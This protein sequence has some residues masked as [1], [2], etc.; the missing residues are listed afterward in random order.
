MLHTNITVNEKGHLTFAGMDTVA[1]AE[2]YGT[3]LMLIDENRIRERA[4][5]YIGA[6]ERYFGGESK[7]LY[8]SKALSFT[9]IYKIIADAGMSIDIVSSGELY[10]AKNAGFPLENAYFHGNN[11]TDFD[12]EFAIDNGIGYFIADGYEEIDKIDSY[13]A[14]KG[15]KQRV[16]LRLT[17]GIDPHTNEK[18]STGKVDC[19]FGTPIETGQAEKY[20]AYVLSKA[21]IELMGY[22]CH[23]GSQVFDCVPFCD[24]A[25]I[26]IEYIAYIKKT[27]GYT[28]KVLNLGGGFG[29]RYVESDPYINIDENI[30]LISE[31]IKARC[32]ENGIA[33]PTIL[34]EPGR[35]MVADAGMTIYSVGTVKT[36][37]DYKSYVSVDGGMTDNPRYTLYGSKY[38]MALAN[39]ANEP[40][41][42]E[43]TVGGRCC[44]SG[45]L[46][47]ENIFIQKPTRGDL[48]AVFVTGAYNYSMASN[49]NRVP[50]PPVVI[51]KDGADRLAVRRETFENLCAL[52]VD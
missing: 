21:N 29:V 49:Y 5:T 23:I 12:I 1:L 9:G 20:I 42:F 45:D 32:A 50:R 37:S 19:K 40:A 41:D 46:L 24:A 4:A 35:S 52:D 36:I 51:I 14:Q 25:D 48:L 28:A 34:M 6:M 2:K 17:P 15:I 13:A 44:E 39:K 18:I 31:H 33:V 47:G 7:P 16:L 3:P 38:T 11:K 10:T 8:A 30:R 27:L 22:H 26:M 43:C